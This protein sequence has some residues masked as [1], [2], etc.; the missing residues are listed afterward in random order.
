MK[1]MKKLFAVLLTLAMVLGMS[2]TTFAADSLDIPVSGAG[3]GAQFKNAQLIEVDTT[4]ETGWKFTSEKVAEQYRNAL[5]VNSDQA[6]IWKLI[7]KVLDD[8][9]AANPGQ[10]VITPTSMPANTEAAT[11][12]QIAKALRDIKN[13]APENFVLIDGKTVTEPGVYYIDVQETGYE[14]NPMAAYVSFDAYTDGVPAGLKSAGTVAKKADIIIEKDDSNDDDVV[15][16]GRDVEYTITTIV[17]YVSYDNNNSYEIK[18]TISGADYNLTNGKMMVKVKVGN[19]QFVEKEAVLSNDN[20]SFTLNLDEYAKDSER[21]YAGEDLVIKY[22]AKV[23]DMEVHNR[24]IGDDGD[25]ETSAHNYL[26]AAT[27]TLT[28]TDLEGNTPL[29]DAEFVVS[30]GNK[31]ATFEEIIENNVVVAYKLSG[32]TENKGD[33]THVITGGEEGTVTVKGLDSTL[34]NGEE[35]LFEEVVAPDGYSIND[36]PVEITWNA[37]TEEEAQITLG[38]VTVNYKKVTVTG[39]ATMNDT[40]LSALPGTGGIGTTI[41]TIGGCLIMIAAAGL[42]FASRR[43]TK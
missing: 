31:Y 22:S 2:M 20:H 14:Y 9:S 15:E 41:F 24:V 38:N 4:K 16:I 36:T 12:G 13:L 3:D 5:G 21:A 27:A 23:T 30:K 34:L 7:K 10:D 11:D 35:Y 26:Y 25:H 32:W 29:K 42:F 6:A 19:A 40:K 8:K 18:D 33:A 28:K 39:N 43:K 1:K 17:P 37:P